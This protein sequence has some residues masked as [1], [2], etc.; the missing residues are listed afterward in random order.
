MTKLFVI[1]AIIFLSNCHQG[2][3]KPSLP[4][5]SGSL[6]SHYQNIKYPL[7]NY[8]PPHPGSY[9]QE[10]NHGAIAYMVEDT[11]LPL[12]NIQFLFASD[13]FAYTT[14]EKARHSL[15][16]DLLFSGGTKSFTPEQLEDSVEFIAA[17]LSAY[18]DDHMSVLSINSL[19]DHTYPLLNLMRQ[20][21]LEPR[22]DSDVLRLQ[23]KK[24]IEGIRHRFDKADNVSDYAFENI[25]YGRHPYNWLISED[26]VKTVST[27][28][29]KSL[30]GTGF[31]MHKVVISVSGMFNKKAMIKHL[32]L[33][34]DQL[35]AAGSKPSTT[36]PPYPGSQSPGTYLVYKDFQQ[37]TIRIGFPGLKR[38]HKD[39]YPLSVANYIFGA[40]GFTS[41]IVARIRTDEGLAYSV[42]SYA[43][44]SYYRKAAIGIYLQ[45]KAESAGQA[46]DLCFEEIQKMIDSGI[47]KQELDRAKDGL[48]GSLPSMFKTSAA[49]ANIFA[50][51]EIW[52]RSP[53][54]FKLYPEKIAA[55]TLEQVN[56]I[57]RKYFIPDSARIVIVGK[58]EI[59]E[60]IEPLSSHIPNPVKTKTFININDL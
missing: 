48:I 49:T 26:N 7:F 5:L 6:P 8:T 53:D 15:Y 51:S 32:N 34:L 46:I 38:P 1:L 31:P 37:A 55:L 42:Y 54:H 21:V 18:L 11:S 36:P 12:V 58:K 13:N 29:L 2:T 16:S 25:F 30:T 50:Q 23:R 41:R 27:N 56:A 47:T 40:G 45:T 59:L 9:R 43:G 22:F 44:S 14:N 60:K 17:G 10:L 33:F 24:L 20:V 39:Y 19:S 28:N 4:Y 57:F 52:G 3:Q 35:Q